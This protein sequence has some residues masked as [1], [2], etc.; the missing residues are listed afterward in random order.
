M[1]QTWLVAVQ[2]YFL[3]FLGCFVLVI[4]GLGSIILKQILDSPQIYQL[5]SKTKYLLSIPWLM[6]IGRDSFC[7]VRFDF[8]QP[9]FRLVPQGLPM[10]EESA[11]IATG[12]TI[13]L[14]GLGD[15]KPVTPSHWQKSFA[16]FSLGSNSQILVANWK[17]YPCQFHWQRGFFSFGNG[18]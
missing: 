6:G 2:K 12:T 17:K 10:F 16:T 8:L 3:V 7:W 18:G 14:A 1:V 13:P 4:K 5:N 15:L 11:N 9:L